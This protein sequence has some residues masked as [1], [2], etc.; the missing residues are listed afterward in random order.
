MD[1]DLF[2]GALLNN[3]FFGVWRGQEFLSHPDRYAVSDEFFKK[4]ILLYQH[5]VSSFREPSMLY[6][7]LW[8]N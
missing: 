6:Y 4:A 7:I 3:S 1:S 5:L 2:Y 8:M